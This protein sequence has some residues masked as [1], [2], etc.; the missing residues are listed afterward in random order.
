MRML[1]V[2]IAGLGTVGQSVVE[3]ISTSGALLESRTGCR[4]EIAA[5]TARE[6]SKDRSAMVAACPWEAD[7]I[8]LAARDD[9][10]VLVELIGG[11]DGMALEAVRTALTAGKHVVTANKAM[12][13]IHGQALAV[14]A[15]TRGVSLLFEAAVAGGIPV[16][17]ALI[18]SL[19]ANEIH[20][21]AGVMNGTCNYILTKMEEEGKPYADV[22]AEAERLGYLE[23]DPNL[24]VGGI[25]AAHKLAIL[26][27][28]AFGT[29]VNYAGIDRAGIDRIS[30]DDIEQARAMGYRIKLLCIARRTD[31]GVEQR[32]QPCLVPRNSPLARVSGATNIVA[33][34]ADPVGQI[35][36][37]GPGAGGGP[38]GSAVVSD[39]VDIARGRA[40]P[41]FGRP[42]ASLMPTTATASVTP[43]PHYLRLL[44]VD[45]PGVLAKVAG[46]LGDAGISI[47]R[48]RQYRHE[49]NTAPVIIVT[50]ATTGDRLNAAMATIAD[51]AISVTD[52]VL[53]RVERG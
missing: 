5:V 36:L 8:Q 13:A 51:P 4:I 44:L 26:A 6:R 7:P 14:L 52:P 19:A 2:G 30:I 34:T 18:D 3:I 48:M 15:E 24:D 16:V 20:A 31:E 47:D 46:A 43:V 28:I 25:D 45:R 37:E 29:P 40:V 11:E 42:A 27:S 10:D 17:K 22:F 39:I 50:H 35:V 9:V 23:A 33:I 38:T 32:T 12:L 1:R 49:S 21:I 41:V 53:I